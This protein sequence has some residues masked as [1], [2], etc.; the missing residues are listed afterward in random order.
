MSKGTKLFIFTII[1]LIGGA[2]IFGQVTR[3]SFDLNNKIAN[4]EEFQHFQAE[5]F[6]YRPMNYFNDDIQTVEE[7]EKAS[8]LIVTVSE[9][10][11]R[12]LVKQATKTTLVIDKVLKGEANSGDE[13]ILYEPAYFIKWMDDHQ[14]G[15]FDSSGYQ[16]IQDG[17]KYILFLSH[18]QAPQG[19]KWSE[20]EKRSFLPTS[21]LYAKYPLTINTEVESQLMDEGQLLETWGQTRD[22]ELLINDKQILNHYISLKNQILTKYLKK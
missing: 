21:Q 4:F 9:V 8:D 10:R 16:L 7:L 22:Y 19:Y 2:F 13:I 1:L 18:L 17:N 11:E 14:N 15:Y 6:S 20:E 3:K 12:E 5:S